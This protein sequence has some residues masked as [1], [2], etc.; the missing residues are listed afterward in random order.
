[1]GE[2]SG[3]TWIIWVTA[4]LTEQIKHSDNCQTCECHAAEVVEFLNITQTIEISC[5]LTA[6]L[7]VIL[8]QQRII[9]RPSHKGCDRQNSAKMQQQKQ[10]VWQGPECLLTLYTK[11]I[12]FASQ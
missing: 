1:V 9:R 5:K 10:H 2:F 7:R 12:F 6:K 3:N 11:S 8:Q 4:V